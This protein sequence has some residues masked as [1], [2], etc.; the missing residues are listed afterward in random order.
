M[1]G[2][3]W[4]SRKYALH[5]SDHTLVPGRMWACIISCRV[6]WLLSGTIW[7]KICLVM[8]STAPKHHCG[9]TAWEWLLPGFWRATRVL[10]MATVWPG[11]PSWNG[12][13]SNSWL[14]TS[15]IKAY[16]STAVWWAMP[17]CMCH[18]NCEHLLVWEMRACNEILRNWALMFFF[19]KGKL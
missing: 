14:Q 19:P 12:W 1:C 17:T 11:P 4:S 2:S 15:R 18:I 6:A 16:Q 13:C 3:C 5:S 8:R 9:G 10:S 7:I